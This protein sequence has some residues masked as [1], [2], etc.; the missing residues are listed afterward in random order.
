MAVPRIFISSTCY[1]LKDIRFQV[2][3]FIEDFGYDPVMSDFGDIFYDF[4]DHVQES[5]K[6]EI[7]KSNMF[8]LIV[9][10]NYGS[11]YHQHDES[12]EINP[13]SVTLQEFKKALEIGIPK[14]IFINK[15]VQYDYDNYERALRKKISDYFLNNDIK[16]E[17]INTIKN[18]IKKDFD[19][20][21]PFPQD[22]YKY[23]FYFIEIIKNLKVNNAIYSFESFD[24][25]K[26]DLK[27]Q[28]AGLLYNALIINKN[29]TNKQINSIE[30]KLERLEN[31]L[32]NFFDNKKIKNNKYTIDIDNYMNEYNIENMIEIK[33]EIKRL[34]TN[35][36]IDPFNRK[37]FEMNEK[38]SQNEVEKF[39]KKARECIIKF[40][41]SETIPTNNL[42]ELIANDKFPI[43]YYV[44][45][46]E[47]EYNDVVKLIAIINNIDEKEINFLYDTIANLFNMNYDDGE[48]PF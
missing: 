42:F 13:D 12:K 37:R 3:H 46:N 17:D 23:I 15:F 24:N 33:S 19:K 14:Y 4:K 45:S 27:K 30:T 2:R 9:G 8:I 43:I 47:V 11:I 48:I 7:E 34:I 22:A 38:F 25:I 39:I 10:N 1:D 18:R 26:L 21:Y 32:K 40:K 5:C 36:C 28:W 35:I 29:V 16:M 20:T 6:N 31:H 41:W 44:Y